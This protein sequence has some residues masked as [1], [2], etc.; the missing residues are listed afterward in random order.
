MLI[1][2]RFQHQPEPEDDRE[3]DNSDEFKDNCNC[4]KS[5]CLKL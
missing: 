3:V 5:R 4:R 1:P 2:M